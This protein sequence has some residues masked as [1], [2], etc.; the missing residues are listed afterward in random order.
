MNTK[1]KREFP[2]GLWA[3]AGFLQ[4]I[5]HIGLR[6]ITEQ[7]LASL[8]EV[9]KAKILQDINISRAR[10]QVLNVNSQIHVR[11]STHRVEQDIRQVELK[12]LQ[13]EIRKLKVLEMQ[14]KLG[15]N[16]AEFETVGYNNDDFADANGLQRYEDR[17]R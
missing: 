9:R 3:F 6:R 8:N 7:E 14:R 5:L 15:L 17:P 2:A 10:Q 13:I 16:A 12:D 11:R 4:I 1:R